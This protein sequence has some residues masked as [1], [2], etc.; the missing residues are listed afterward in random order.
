VR[1]HIVA[2]HLLVLALALGLS[3]VTVRAV[4]L[5]R[6]DERIS[7]ELV[8]EA[9]ELRTLAGGLDP[10]TGEPFGSAVDRLFEVF[11]QRN[12]TAPNETLVTFVDGRPFLRSAAEPPVRLDLDPG[13]ARRWGEA[14]EPLR[15]R[16][17]HP[18]VGLVDYLAVPVVDSGEP[19]GVFVVIYFNGLE[20]G[21]VDEV[22]AVS[23]AVGF[24]ALLLA[25]GI[26]WNVGSRVLAP[27][28]AVTGTAHR[29]TESDL[30]S[31]IE[32][33]GADEVSM[34][35]R[36]F[37]SM[38][39]R[40]EAAFGSQRE[41]IDDAGHELRTPITIIRGHLEL[42]DH[43][44]PDERAETIAL[45]LDELDRMHR[46]VEDLL[47][48]TKAERPDFL[49]LDE[50]DVATL[51]DELSVKARALGDRAWAVDACGSGTIVADR[52][53]LT[54]ALM[55]LAENATR[56]TA[57]GDVIAI[58]SAADAV[59][60]RFWVRDMGTGVAGAGMSRLFDRFARGAYPRGERDGSGLGLAIVKAIAEAHHG[61]VEVDSVAGE[62]SRFTV[63]VPAPQPVLAAAGDR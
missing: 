6:L 51:T 3:I 45:V 12:I 63:V 30:T 26:I 47:L 42:L 9:E 25:A 50:V 61:R 49:R 19:A 29:I 46:M 15:G 53:R 18:D 41:F 31:R 52:Q 10:A 16:V 32:V 1:L 56:H 8:Q 21:E 34:L 24:L 13:F 27:V 43:T 17:E 44:D 4:L 36:T 48:L 40:L 60:A 7:R 22:V 35:A 5:A 37:N 59:E 23:G 58:G 11:L 33:T 28:R 2:W 20:R 55:E 54:E 39:D 57:P 14:D 62:G 38:L